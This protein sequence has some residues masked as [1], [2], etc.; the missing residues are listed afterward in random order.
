MKTKLQETAELPSAGKNGTLPSLIRFFDRN[1]AILA[2]IFV[3][4]IGIFFAPNFFTPDGQS[5]LVRELSRFGI[6]AAGMT[7]VIITGGI[8]LSVGSIL[9]LS[10]VL[11]SIFVIRLGVPWP[12]AVVMCLGLGGVIGFVNGS[13]V[14]QFGIQPFV[15]TLAMMV[16]ARGMAKLVSNQEKISTFFMNIKGDWVTVPMPKIFLWLDG[17]IPGTKIPMIFFILLFCI[18]ILWFLSSKTPFGRYLYAIGGNEDAARLA[19]VRVKS[20]KTWAYIICSMTA[21]LAGICQAAAERQGDPESG[22]T[23]ELTAIAMVVI[24]GTTLTGGEGGVKYT[25]L[26][27]L[28]IGCIDKIL[29]LRGVN[30]AG[31][32]IATG[33]IIIGAVLIQFR[34]KD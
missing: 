22:Q 24:G 25:L 13:F 33:V 1:R 3:F 34:K 5:G 15:A 27:A 21:A 16:A 26:G 10:A 8:D 11:F 28:I 7:L 4:L 32:L 12:L 30:E 17:S 6:L 23:Y 14:T 31:R 29:S 20:N 19:G 2:F 18:G 9:G